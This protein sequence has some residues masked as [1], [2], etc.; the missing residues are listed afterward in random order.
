[1]PGLYDQIESQL[2]G[3]E[4]PKSK[5]FFDRLSRELDDRTDGITTTDLINLKGAQKTV[6][7]FMLRNTEAA[8][9]GMTISDIRAKLPDI[10]SDLPKALTELTNQGWLFVSGE[11]PNHRYR[12]HMRRKRG[13]ELGLGIWSTL[14]ARFEE[15]KDT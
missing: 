8:T 14:A 10:A 1:M 4:S 7:L 6:M 15:R 2:D 5:P 13:S 3:D 9:Q 12:I 11:V